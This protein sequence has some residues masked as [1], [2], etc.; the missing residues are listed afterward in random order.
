MLCMYRVDKLSKSDVITKRYRLKRRLIDLYDLIVR[1]PRGI[2]EKVLVTTIP[3]SGSH[4]LTDTLSMFPVFF[5]NHLILWPYLQI[6]D[7]VWDLQNIPYMRYA[8]GHLG[9]TNESI[10]LSNNLSLKVIVMLRDPRDVVLS[11]VDHVMS[12]RP[13]FLKKYYLSLSNYE[14]RVQSA[15]QGAPNDSYP[16][17]EQLDKSGIYSMYPGFSDIGCVCR[18][19]LKWQE[20]HDVLFVSFE[21]L[22]GQKGGGNDDRQRKEVRRII[23][24]LGFDLSDMKIDNICTKIYNPTSPQFN[25]GKIGRWKESKIFTERNRDLFKKICGNELILMGYEKSIDW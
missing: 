10:K 14:E 16:Y 7:Y 4:L 22:I 5:R 13:Q 11:F 8:W 6:A 15:I 18:S 25:K 12:K 2:G 19:Y 21:A 9:A 20:Y 24:F 17:E 23:D 3:K 1:R